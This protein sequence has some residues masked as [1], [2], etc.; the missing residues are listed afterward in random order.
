MN[1]T[2][3]CGTAARIAQR[4]TIAS[5]GPLAIEP[6]GRGLIND[7]FRVTA[8]A[9]RWVLQRINGQ[10]FPDPEGI[11]ANLSRLG[12]HLARQGVVDLTWPELARTT[13]GATWTRDE[14]G[15][16]WRLMSFIPGQP[17]ERIESDPQ[18]AE[19]GRLLGSFHRAVADLDPASL[20][21]TLPGFHVT[22]GYLESF[23][24]VSREVDAAHEV[25]LDE[26]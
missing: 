1:S 25:G 23:D 18:A 5:G 2:D 26:A 8:G 20:E 24:R 19:V 16:V 9:D 7:S 10:V 3:L 4:F 14:A 6:L 22:P 12:A 17:L 15:A 13:E 21:V 11:M